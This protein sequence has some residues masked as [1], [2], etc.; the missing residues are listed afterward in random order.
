MNKTIEQAEKECREAWKQNPSD[1]GWCIHHEI[2]MEKLTEP[3]ENRI[4]FILKYKATEELITRLDNLRPVISPVAIK[5]KKAYEEAIALA[6]KAYEEAIAPAW[7]AYEEAIAP[8]KKTYDEA[9]APAEKTYYKAAASARKA[10]EEAIALA[11]KA[12]EEAIAPA[13]KAY[14]EAIALAWKSYKKAIAPALKAY[15]EAIAPAHVQEVP[16]HTW[17]GKSIF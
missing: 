15:D 1:Y 12:Y 2:E 9:I 13:W 17:N 10:Y 3:I 6:W 8:A 4:S 11:W 16:G 7:K 14:E 5:A